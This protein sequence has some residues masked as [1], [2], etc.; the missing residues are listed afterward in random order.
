MFRTFGKKI[1]ADLSKMQSECPGEQFEEK[2]FFWKNYMFLLIVI[3]LRP[4]L[5][6]NFD[7][8]F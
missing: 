1:S 6:E 7:G 4:K 3:G 8:N 2:N 5:F